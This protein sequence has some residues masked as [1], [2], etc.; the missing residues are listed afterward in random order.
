MLFS[1][2]VWADPS[3]PPCP[4]CPTSPIDGGLIWLLIAGAGFAVKKIYD[5]NKS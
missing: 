5:H 4:D 1:S 2:A 3:V